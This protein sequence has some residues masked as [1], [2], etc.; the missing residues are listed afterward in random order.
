[1]AYQKA[2]WHTDAAGRRIGW[3]WPEDFETLMST[4]YGEKAWVPLFCDEFD[5]AK[6][7][8]YRWRDGRVPIP[9]HIAH[10]VLALGRMKMQGVPLDELTA[11]WLPDKTEATVPPA[12]KVLDATKA[13]V[14]RA[15]KGS[16]LKAAQDAAKDKKSPPKAA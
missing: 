2:W 13:P 6:P 3:L 15:P 14:K 7:T 10:L 16:R 12:A 5:F 11:D 4:Y 1:M 8:V 9:K